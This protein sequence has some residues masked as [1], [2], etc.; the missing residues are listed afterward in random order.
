MQVTY[1][2]YPGTLGVPYI[3]YIIADR[4]VIPEEHRPYYSE[5]VVYLPYSYQPNDRKRPIGETPPSRDAVGLPETGFVFAS[6]NSTYKIT[7]EIFEIW[8]RL[9]NDVE[10]S[11]LWLFEDN[12]SSMIN[13]RREARSRGIDAER[14]VFAKRKPPD[15]H[16]A[17]QRLAD[18]FLDTYPINAHATASDALWAGLPVL[19][20]RGDVFPAR[21]AASLLLALGLPDLVT[22][23]L[24]EYEQ[25]ARTL[26]H[27]PSRLAAIRAKLLRNHDTT[28]LFD[29]ARY[30]R[31]LEAAF[32][33]MWQ[34]SE[35]NLPPID[36]AVD[37][38]L[39]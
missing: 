38:T 21:V 36:F 32:T 27:E 37:P 10:N 3:D 19:T 13:L 17:R 11:V 12:V 15:Q 24:A 29:T 33:V 2:G 23:S 39:S 28:P 9:L 7:T 34:R 30:T 14:L 16:L 25:L 18:L 35:V 8:M 20:C 26:A 31:H 5:K 1:P 6:L 22:N 4:I